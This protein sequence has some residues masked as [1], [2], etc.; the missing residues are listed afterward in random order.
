MRFLLSILLLVFIYQQAIANTVCY[1]L[2]WGHAD[3]AIERRDLSL[4]WDFDV[5][6]QSQDGNSIILT[7]L[8]FL[9]GTRASSLNEIKSHEVEVSKIENKAIADGYQ[10]DIEKMKF[11]SSGTSYL[12]PQGT[13]SMNPDEAETFI[14][15]LH[16]D[17]GS[18]RIKN[19]GTPKKPTDPANMN[20]GPVVDKSVLYLGKTEDTYETE[21]FKISD[22]A[23]PL[24]KGTTPQNGLKV[25]APQNISD[26]C[27]KEMNEGWQDRIMHEVHIPIR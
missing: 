17:G 27:K 6:R 19:H 26:A 15:C 22:A 25:L 1:D 13:K 8:S 21:A 16:P 23:L 18:I 20:H 2:G 11:D 14:N 9:Q 10:C 5:L 7:L 3:R 4:I 24:P 12:T